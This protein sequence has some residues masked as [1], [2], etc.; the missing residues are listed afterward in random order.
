MAW[1]DDPSVYYRPDAGT[2]EP[3]SQGD[4]VIA[5]TSVIYLGSGD[6]D[7]AGPTDL[8]QSRKVAIWIAS[9]DEYPAAPAIAAEVQWGLAIVMPHSCAMEKEWN[10]RVQELIAAGH[11]EQKA[12]EL[13]SEDESLDPALALAPLLGYEQ[14]SESA[15]APTR[16]GDRIGSFP[17]C[18]QE[19]IPESFVDLNRV[20]SVHYK[21]VP[22]AQR[23]A[24]L[25][26]LALAHF[27]HRLAMNFAFRAIDKFDAISR[28]VG[29]T[30]VEVV[31][32]VRTKNKLVVDL[33]LEDGS[34]IT[35]EGN[36][37]PEQARAA[38]VRP[39]RA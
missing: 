30:I 4:I 15:R 16:T 25:S 13:A 22:S 27:Q 14:L 28:A 29:H 38:P 24:S 34:A 5:P 17:I 37:R 6:R 23:V 3:I 20:M 32:T 39:P 2:S 35:T 31:A 19:T 18:G 9:S 12:I 7:V 36:A 11:H 21:V 8:G 10:E 33:M 1:Y 26:D